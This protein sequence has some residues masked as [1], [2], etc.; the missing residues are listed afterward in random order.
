MYIC[1]KER[2]RVRRLSTNRRN[3]K[4]EKKTIA[5]NI[6]YTYAFT[7]SMNNKRRERE[8]RELI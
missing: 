5:K 2:E 8:R 3:L 6:Q 1:M 4:R 7:E